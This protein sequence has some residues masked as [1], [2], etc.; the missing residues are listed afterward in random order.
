MVGWMKMPLGA[1]AGLSPGDFVL[2]VDP[3]KGAQQPLPP[4]QKILWRSS[5]RN[6]SGRG[7]KHKRGS[8]V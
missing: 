2:D 7:V 4:L 3:L 8:K 6:P 5:K 1:E